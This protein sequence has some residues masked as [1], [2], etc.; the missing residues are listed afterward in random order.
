MKEITERIEKELKHLEEYTATPGNGCT[1]LPFTKEARMAV[2]Y[3]KERMLDAGLAVHEDEAGNVFGVLEGEDPNLPCV[4]MGS[5]YDSVMSGGNYDGIAGVVSAIDVA[6][7]LKERGV[8]L[9]RNY[10]AVGF[11]DEEG[12]RFG[13]G[14]FGSGAML[15]VY[16][17]DYCKK[18]HDTDG[19][20][21]YDAMKGYG[22]DAEK[23][24]DA[25]WKKDSIEYFI[26]SHIEQG[27]V[28]D[29]EGTE[30]G[31]VEGIVGLQRYMVTVNGR[32][33]HAGTTPM[34][35]RHDAVEAAAGVIAKIPQWARD[36]QDET[37]ATVGYVK[38]FPGGVNIV[39]EKVEFSVDV[40]SMNNEHI[41]TIVSKM[42]QELQALS[43]K[44]GTT[45]DMLEKLRIEPLHLS[46]DLL[47]ILAE[48]CKKHG[49]SNR[50]MCS[51]AGHDTLE[52]GQNGIPSVMLFIP[53]KD[54]RSHCPVEWSS[55]EDV[56]KAAQV[57]ADLVEELVTK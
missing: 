6:R 40:R 43:D 17:V 23:L 10:V 47:K 38:S 41:E 37:V 24:K 33:D 42:K 28:L 54:G 5:H 30:L 49:Y 12:T 31:L 11:C 2:D 18:F 51:G 56:A 22:L 1:R 52:I 25:A 19:V 45:F 36:Y 46:E 29:S 44:C 55:Y 21:I 27:A 34:N 4:M 39:A 14:Y 53:S 8:K 16:D 15:G 26:E 50:R 7:Q 48:S 35:M 3:L 20:S 32:A 57:A 9:K 13:T